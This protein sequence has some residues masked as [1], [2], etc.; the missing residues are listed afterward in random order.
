MTSNISLHP[1][2]LWA[3]RK[4][5]VFITIEIWEVQNEKIDVQADKISFSGSHGQSKQGYSFS[6]EFYEPIDPE[7]RIK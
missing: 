3:Q 1:V 4:D 7:V 2:V 6:L 5:K